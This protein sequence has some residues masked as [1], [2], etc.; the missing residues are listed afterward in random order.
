[1]PVS[2]PVSISFIFNGMGYHEYYYTVLGVI[3][4][5]TMKVGISTILMQWL[6]IFEKLS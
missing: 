3:L 5:V 2:S 4:P 6:S 1:M